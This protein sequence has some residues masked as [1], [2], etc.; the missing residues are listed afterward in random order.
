MSGDRRHAKHAV[1]RPLDGGVR[2]H[3]GHW[4]RQYS[5]QLQKRKRTKRARWAKAAP[6]ATKRTRARVSSPRLHTSK[7]A[8]LAIGSNRPTRNHTVWPTQ[9]M[10]VYRAIC[11]ELQVYESNHSRKNGARQPSSQEAPPPHTTH[12]EKAAL[13]KYGSTQRPVFMPPNVRHE[14]Q[15]T[16]RAGLGKQPFGARRCLSARWRG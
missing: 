8:N 7:E 12:Q 14:R 11:S 4:Q 6:C 3:F 10:S 16:A 15:T 13:A 1:G 2:R 5:R 9:Q